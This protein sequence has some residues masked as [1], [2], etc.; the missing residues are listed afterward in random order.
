MMKDFLTDIAPEEFNCRIFQLLS[1][2][3][4]LLAAG[5]LAAG[6][7]NAMTVGWGM[8]GTMWNLPVVTAAVR[9]QRHTLEFMNEYETFTL[10]AFPESCRAILAFCGSHSGRDEDKFAACNLTLAAASRVAAPAFAEAELVIEC[11]KIYIDKLLGKNFLEK[12]ILKDCYPQRDFHHLFIGSVVHISGTEAYRH[13]REND[14]K[15]GA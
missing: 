14:E 3:W 2:R 15:A 8:M 12:S 6:K 10:S 11:R 4:M 13:N 9:P 5:D 7:F 1:K